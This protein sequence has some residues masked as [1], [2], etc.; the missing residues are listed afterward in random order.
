M[1]NIS[2]SFFL[3]LNSGSDK[4][5]RVYD[6]RNTKRPFK[7]L[8]PESLRSNENGYQTVTCCVY[9]NT[10]SEILASYGDQDIFLFENHPAIET[11]RVLHNYSGHW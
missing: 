3:P 1:H 4:F 6:Y 11:G 5:V 2:Q 10:G 9:N 8:C 7:Q